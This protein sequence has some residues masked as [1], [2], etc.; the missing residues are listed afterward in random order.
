[1][2]FDDIWS[3]LSESMV[4]YLPEMLT[5][6]GLLIAGWLIAGLAGWLVRRGLIAAH[7]EERLHDSDIGLAV[8]RMTSRPAHLAGRLTFWAVLLGFV[9]LAVLALGVP[10]LTAAVGA[11]YAYLP[12]LIAAAL[13]VV[14]AA[15]ISIILR[16]VAKRTLAGTP[17]GA[18]A[19]V[20]LPIVIMTVAAFMALSELGVAQDIVTITFAAVVGSLALGMALAFGLGGRQVASKLLEDA[21]ANGHE[22]VRQLQADLA[23]ARQRAGVTPDLVE[24]PKLA[25]GT[26]PEAAAESEAAPVWGASPAFGETV[27]SAAAA[28]KP[29][30]KGAKSANSRKLKK[31][32]SRPSRPSSAE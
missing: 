19:A 18:V 14:I 10:A 25:Q 30:R 20:A 32:V 15:V 17:T 6:L 5:A 24:E 21:Y 28:K 9:T 4:G 12:H 2:T 7:L 11:L 26:E 22:S 27:S 1:M 3:T 31:S 16:A 13:I 29:Q 23:L 8:D